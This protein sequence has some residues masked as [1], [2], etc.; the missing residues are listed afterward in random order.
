M[1]L[2][3]T[4][5]RDLL[6]TLDPES[7]MKLVRVTMELISKEPIKTAELTARI[8]RAFVNRVEVKGDD[9]SVVSHFDERLLASPVQNRLQGVLFIQVFLK[10][11]WNPNAD[12]EHVLVAL[13]EDTSF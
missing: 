10:S 11:I 8:F 7:V 4:G 2:R 12:G 3:N 6:E 13:D 9:V 5:L 1:E